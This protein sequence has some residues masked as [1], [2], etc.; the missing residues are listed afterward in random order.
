M[1]QCNTNNY[2]TSSS[3]NQFHPD[4]FQKYK[5]YIRKNVREVPNFEKYVDMWSNMHSWYKHLYGGVTAYPLIC[6]ASIQGKIEFQPIIVFRRLND[7]RFKAILYAHFIENKDPSRVN[8]PSEDCLNV[9]NSLFEYLE[10][11]YS[12]VM[13]TNFGGCNKQD[14]EQQ[15]I[16]VQQFTKLWN[17]INN[18]SP[19]DY[20]I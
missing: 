18:P 4:I 3:A 8:F 12:F 15:K 17:D 13:D 1:S 19:D 5:D 16:C 7:D 11:N 6:Y 2:Q 10:K 20:S 14:E 9:M